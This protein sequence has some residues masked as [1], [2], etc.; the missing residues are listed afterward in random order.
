MY[1]HLVLA[2][3]LSFIYSNN[4]LI[5]S[6]KKEKFKTH[7]CSENTQMRYQGEKITAKFVALLNVE[8]IKKKCH[9]IHQTKRW[10]WRLRTTVAYFCMKTKCEELS[11]WDLIQFSLRTKPPQNV[12]QSEKYISDLQSFKSLHTVITVQD[13]W[14]HP[15]WVP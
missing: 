14:L 6:Y 7:C 2:P 1:W 9:F 10:G 5:E 15:L 4:L 8:A 11:N 13:E 12:A 3:M